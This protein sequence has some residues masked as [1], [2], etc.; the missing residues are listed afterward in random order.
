MAKVGVYRIGFASQA[1]VDDSWSVQQQQQ[2]VVKGQPTQNELLTVKWFSSFDQ[3]QASLTEKLVDDEN[4]QCFEATLNF[5]VRKDSDIA[6]AKKWMKRP[7]KMYVDA[8]D[9]T[10][11]TMGT[12]QYPVWMQ[13]S[14]TY[15]G[16]DTREI[17]IEVVYRTLNGI[18]NK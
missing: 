13:T 18:M 6:L 3:K 8:V 4:G 10:M 5:T 14:N 7:V 15:E 12:K 17:N 16:I 11:Y 1:E 9:R 2:P